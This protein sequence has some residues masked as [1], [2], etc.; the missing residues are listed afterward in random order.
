MEP[1]LLLPFIGSRRLMARAADVIHG[2]Q[3]AAEI[4]WTQA[5][6]EILWFQAAAEIH[7]PQ[8]AS[9]GRRIPWFHRLRVPPTEF[10]SRAIRR[11]AISMR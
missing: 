8:A 10:D 1:L 2:L 5:A 11:A 9:G 4:H 7:W 3:A 6:A